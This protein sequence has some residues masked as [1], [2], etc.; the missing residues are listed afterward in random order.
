LRQAHY[1]NY[2]DNLLDTADLTNAEAYL[3][4]LA[5]EIEETAQ[6]IR[7]YMAKES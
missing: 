1:A 6:H 7:A 3:T 5:G 2:Q 4:K